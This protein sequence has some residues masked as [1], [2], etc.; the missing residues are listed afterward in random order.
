[1]KVVRN[2]FY[3][4]KHLWKASPKRVFF[5]ML[6]SILDYSVDTIITLFLLRFIIDSLQKQR[7]FLEVIF[8]LCGILSLTLINNTVLSWY[9]HKIFPEGRVQTQEY[10]MNKIYTQAISVDLSCYENPQF[11]DTYTKANEEIFKRSEHILQN[12][13]WIVGMLFSGVATVVAIV[14]YEPLLLI[15]AILP[16]FIEQFVSRKYTYYKYLQN[17]ETTYERRQMD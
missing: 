2:N 14:V 11:Y 13:T 7:P 1:M 4:L 12:L 10:L 17:K 8:Y 15:V 9:N 3:M 6:S 16:V 5:G